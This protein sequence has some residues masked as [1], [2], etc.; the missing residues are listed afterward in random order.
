M[1]SV[2]GKLKLEMA[3]Y[4][5]VAAFSQFASELDKA[6]QMQLIRGQRLTELLKQDLASPMNVVDQV[7]SIFAGGTGVLDAITNQQVKAFEIGVLAH[8]KDKYP[9]VAET[10]RTPKAVSK[11]IEETL[12]KAVLEFGRRVQ[13][14]IR[15]H[16]DTQGNPGAH[17]SREEHPADH[18]SDEAGCRGTLKKATDRVLEARQTADH[19][20]GLMQ[21]IAAAR[22]PASHPLM[23]KR[24]I[25]KV[26]C[27]VLLTSD[28]GLA[29]AY[30][31]GLIRKTVE[32]MK[33]QPGQGSLITVGKKGPQFFGKR[34]YTLLHS[35]TVPTSEAN[36][37]GRRRRDASRASDL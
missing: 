15:K 14:N 11:D 23:D 27:I 8:V 18:E 22:R 16:G 2:A 24:E 13:G 36:P 21:S 26:Q 32:F 29:G 10:I 4:R 33:E 30:N 17:K 34:G 3:Q 7:I 37:F 19:M 20:R 12:R 25:K 35:M 31:S 6:T 5:D 1:K 28:R 9:E